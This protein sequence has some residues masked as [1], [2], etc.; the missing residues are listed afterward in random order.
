M[1]TAEQMI[2]DGILLGM[3]LCLAWIAWQQKQEIEALRNEQRTHRVEFGNK[4]A[5]LEQLTCYDALTGLRNQ[6]MFEDELATML[7]N[8]T[9]LALIYIDLDGLKRVNP[10][11]GHQVADKMIRCAAKAI[12]ASL[13]R[14]TDRKHV[15]RRGTAADE[16]LVMLERADLTTGILL[17]EQILM[18]LRMLPTPTTASIGV[19]AWDGH[20]CM[21]T[22]DLERAAELEMERAKADGRNRVHAPTPP[23]SPN[24]E[25]AKAEQES[26]TVA[27]RCA[28]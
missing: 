14:R 5:L 1:N 4:L 28:A 19:T 12:R 23:K 22:D 25:R 18:A 16:F 26:P 11:R 7:R 2:F 6:R 10:E 9:P 3:L 13:Q 17:A 15:Y 27:K 21:T 20:S 8:R 24:R